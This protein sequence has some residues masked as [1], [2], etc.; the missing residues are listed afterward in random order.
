MA[1]HFYRTVYLLCPALV[2]TGGPEALH[3]LARAL[4]DFGHNVRMVYLHD[5]MPER[6]SGGRVIFPSIADPMPPEYAH[7]EIPSTFQI[8]DDPANAIVFPEIFPAVT[9]HFSHLVPHMCGSASTMAD[10]LS[11]RSVAS[12]QSGGKVGSIC[13]SPIM[14]STG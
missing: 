14:P 12:R 7:Y 8:E 11:K 2:R 13:A 3:Q 4:C 10:G 9:R 6:V 5:A 1:T